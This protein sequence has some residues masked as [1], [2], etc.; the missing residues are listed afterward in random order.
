[1]IFFYYNDLILITVFFIVGRIFEVHICLYFWLVY[2]T[3][4]FLRAQEIL[5]MKCNM[6]RK[7][8][9]DRNSWVFFMNCWTKIPYQIC[10]HCLHHLFLFLSYFLLGL[11]LRT[12]CYHVQIC[13]S[14]KSHSACFCRKTVQ[15]FFSVFINWFFLLSLIPRPLS[16]IDM[17]VLKKTEKMYKK[18][19]KML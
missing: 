4:K 19:E 9:E 14:I 13:Q 1:M 16:W 18:N 10:C 8:W 7:F 2:F 3:I 5:V 12:K 15:T 17:Y 6:A 11:G